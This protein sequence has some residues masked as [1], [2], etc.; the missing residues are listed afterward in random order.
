MFWTRAGL[1]TDGLLLSVVASVVEMFYFFLLFH[2]TGVT[3][4][5]YMNPYVIKSYMFTFRCLWM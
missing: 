2:R 4:P 5:P 3:F 1:R